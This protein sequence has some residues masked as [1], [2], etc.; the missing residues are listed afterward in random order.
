MKTFELHNCFLVENIKGTPDKIYLAIPSSN[1]PST[2]CFSHKY[3]FN[4]EWLQ[5]FPDDLEAKKFKFLKVGD[6][7]Y[8]FKLEKCSNSSDIYYISLTVV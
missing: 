2:F 5:I 4:K 3:L 6:V 1:L 8:T 7:S